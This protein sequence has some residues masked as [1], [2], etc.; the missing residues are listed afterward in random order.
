MQKISREKFIEKKKSDTIV[1]YGC[2]YSINDLTEDD[3]HKLQKFDG[4]GFNWFLK[5]KI[6]TTFY[7]LREQGIKS[8]NFQGERETDLIDGLRNKNYD[9]T[10]LIIDDMSGSVRKWREK[11]HHS[12]EHFHKKILHDGIIVKE[13]FSKKE[14][15]EFDS[16]WGERDKR[17]S[18]ITENMMK[19]DI[20]DNGLIYDFC[21]I[22]PVLHIVS[23]LKYKRIIFV[24]VDLY[25]HRYFWLPRET[26]RQVTRINGR[27]LVGHHY[28]AKYTC[29]LISVYP[30]IAD[31]EVF[32]FSD[33]SLLSKY[34]P[35]WKGQA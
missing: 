9:K 12:N 34:I 35:T 6:P 11:N 30:K 3:K 1:I 20:F 19:Y 33:K 21:S 23:Y 17:C 15:R 25:D 13:V 2:G 32:T 4:I 5:S 18:I 31:K 26:L 8:S 10:C 27:S 22:V 14:F 16:G 28:V 7:F 24:G 29:T